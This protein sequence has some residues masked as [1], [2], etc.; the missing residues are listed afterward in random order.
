MSTGPLLGS[1]L[2]R[3][4]RGPTRNSGLGWV[5]M[6]TCPYAAEG[7]AASSS[8]VRSARL[9]PNRRELPSVVGI[10]RELLLDQA[11]LEQGVLHHGQRLDVDA[12]VDRQQRTR[13]LVRGEHGLR[14]PA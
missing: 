12:P 5:A 2:A 10:E 3:I 14:S 4:D 11:V 1:T 6:K 9:D 13:D 7:A 8:A